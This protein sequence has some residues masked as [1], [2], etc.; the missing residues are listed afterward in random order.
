MSQYADSYVYE[1]RQNPFTGTGHVPG[2]P[3]LVAK[4]GSQKVSE[5]IIVRIDSDGT[6]TVV[7][8]TKAKNDLDKKDKIFNLLK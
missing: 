5:G 6:E 4:G 8:V 3:E 1:S 7:A 2:A